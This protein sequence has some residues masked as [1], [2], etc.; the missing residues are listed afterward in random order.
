MRDSQKITWFRASAAVFIGSKTLKMRPKGSPETSVTSNL[1]GVLSQNI[2]NLKLLLFKLSVN[3]LETQRSKERPFRYGDTSIF[4]VGVCYWVQAGSGSHPGYY[5]WVSQAPSATAK[6]PEHQSTDLDLMAT[7]LMEGAT[8][9][10]T[11][12]DI[13]REVI[14]ASTNAHTRA[15]AHT[16]THTHTHTQLYRQDSITEKQRP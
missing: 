7:S 13:N 12:I 5:L 3:G 1:S 16:R 4:I 2:E 8:P 10:L 9:P 6:R 11:K 14:H 15:L